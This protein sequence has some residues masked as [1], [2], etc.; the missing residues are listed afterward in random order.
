[1]SYYDRQRDTIEL[2]TLLDHV[3]YK[4]VGN[5]PGRIEGRDT[6]QS[7]TIFHKRGLHP[8]SLVLRVFMGL[9]RTNTSF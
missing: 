5:V 1:M 4:N 7:T 2:I 3:P 6:K 8:N 9:Q